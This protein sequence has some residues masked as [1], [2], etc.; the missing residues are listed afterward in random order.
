M[1]YS[2]RA[3]MNILKWLFQTSRYRSQTSYNNRYHLHF[4]HS[5]HPWYYYKYIIIIIIIII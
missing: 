2:A 3:T 1:R 4:L 5:P